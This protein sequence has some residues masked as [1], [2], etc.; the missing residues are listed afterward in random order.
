[1]SE[2]TRRGMAEEPNGSGGRVTFTVKELFVEIRD[3]VKA[4][5]VKMDQH[6]EALEDRIV[7]LETTRVE[8]GTLVDL[9]VRVDRLERKFIYG[10]GFITALNLVA[11]YALAVY[12]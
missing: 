8:Q 10:A 4:L 1:M 7:S 6:R 3:Q 12:L 9:P 11:G 2:T 5:D